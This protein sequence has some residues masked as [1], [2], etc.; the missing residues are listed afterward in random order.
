MTK[1]V[2][3]VVS[4]DFLKT[5]LSGVPDN[6]IG[7]PNDLSILSESPRLFLKVDCNGLKYVAFGTSTN[8]SGRLHFSD[9]LLYHIVVMLLCEHGQRGESSDVPFSLSFQ[10]IL[11]LFSSSIVC[12]LTG[13]KAGRVV[14]AREESDRVA[15]CQSFQKSLHS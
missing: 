13:H 12:Y 10:E 15:R 4:C 5:L 14:G 1:N 2:A 3:P 7:S 9:D 6:S 11:A 8:I